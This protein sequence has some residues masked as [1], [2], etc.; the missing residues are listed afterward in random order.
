MPRSLHNLSVR[1]LGT[2]LRVN[3]HPNPVI[4]PPARY[5]PSISLPELADVADGPAGH[6]T[7]GTAM[8]AL[9][10]ALPSKG[11]DLTLTD[12][13]SAQMLDSVRFG[14]TGS[15]EPFYLSACDITENLAASQTYCPSGRCLIASWQYKL[16]ATQGGA[17]VPLVGRPSYHDS[18]PVSD[19][20]S[21]TWRL[22]VTHASPMSSAVRARRA[23]TG[24]LEGSSY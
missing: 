13:P 18:P 19:G 22:I 9:A 4:S 1:I 17:P 7:V 20:M 5:K 23:R 11:Y 15:Q 3:C 21:I 12:L 24:V 6:P 8:A 16:Q 2:Y 14:P 10:R